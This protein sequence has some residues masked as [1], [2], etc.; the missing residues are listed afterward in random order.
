[1]IVAVHCTLSPA[2]LIVAMIF[3]CVL[4]SVLAKCSAVNDT[5]NS[6]GVLWS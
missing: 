6:G 4:I 2:R 5:V 1:M 3:S